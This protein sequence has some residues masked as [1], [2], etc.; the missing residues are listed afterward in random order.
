[1]SEDH[2]HFMDRA[3]RLARK[4]EG[5]A[6]PN[7]MVGAVI[8]KDGRIIGEG[9][10]VCC[11]ESHAEINAI[12]GAR[13]SIAGATFYVTLEPC[14]HQGRTPPCVQ[15]LIKEQPARVVI[16]AID[17][18]PVVAGRGVAALRAQ[19]IETVV[20]VREEECRRLNE[21]FFKFMT[22][23]LPFVTLKYAQTLDGRIAGAGGHSRWISSLPARRYAHRLR[24]VH[25]AVLVGT[26]TV[27]HDDPELTV[28]LVRGKNPLRIILDSRLDIPLKAGV[29]RNQDRA[30]TL[31][32]AAVNAPEDK[33]RALAGLGVET[34]LVAAAPGGINL[35]ELFRKLGQRGI[36]SVLVEGGGAIITSVLR[37]RLADRLAIVV[38]PKII[39]RGVDAVGELGLTTMD[40]ALQLT[41]VQWRRLGPDILCTGD[42]AGNGY[43]PAKGESAGRGTE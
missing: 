17:P 30:P 5:R 14:T 13:E 26:G 28:R 15:A 34:L 1:M 22:T 8:V 6:S 19:G 23:G 36:T 18:N 38:A 11:G 20:G 16:G 43:G 7:P 9:Y 27:R 25:D 10:H 37:E 39:G 3:L 41:A 40:Q 32:V 2:E 42:I 24:S 35:P 12:R 4:G 29:F 33:L 31:V 21:K